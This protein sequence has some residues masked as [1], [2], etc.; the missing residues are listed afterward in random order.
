MDRFAEHRGASGNARS[1][2]LGDGNEKIPDEGRDDSR[3]GRMLYHCPG[4]PPRRV[5]VA[6]V[7]GMPVAEHGPGD[8]LQGPVVL[9]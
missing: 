8:P 2:C 6:K 4:E 7:T 1:N 5:I 3:S 9:E